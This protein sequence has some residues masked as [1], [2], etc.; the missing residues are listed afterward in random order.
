MFTGQAYSRFENPKN[1]EDF[2]QLNFFRFEL[3]KYQLVTI[4]L[5]SCMSQFP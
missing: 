3:G 2:A 1:S 4:P 5:G